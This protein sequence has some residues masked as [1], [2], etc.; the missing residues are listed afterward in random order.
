MSHFINI[1]F[2]KQEELD[3]IAVESVLN[4]ANLPLNEDETTY[5][6][7]DLSLIHI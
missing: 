1:V 3:D 5:S 7:Y 6:A 2:N 4:G